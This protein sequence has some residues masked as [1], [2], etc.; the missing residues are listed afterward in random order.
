MSKKYQITVRPVEETEPGH[1]QFLSRIEVITIDPVGFNGAGNEVYE[2]E[3]EDTD[4]GFV[5]SQCELTDGIVT[6]FQI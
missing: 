4:A 1:L 5:E 3:V 2:V 6:Y